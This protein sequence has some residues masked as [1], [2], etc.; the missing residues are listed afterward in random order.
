VNGV[1][2]Q[3]ELQ[4]LL[5]N[6]RTKAEEP[7]KEKLPTSL[8]APP[9]ETPEVSTEEFFLFHPDNPASSSSYINMKYATK[10]TGRTVILSVVNGV[11]R[12]DNLAT[13]NELIRQ[14]FV[15]MYSRPKGGNDG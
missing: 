8:E 7:S 9:L 11:I 2:T 10:V 1:L 13:R 5:K 12:T 15:L 3:K 14:G 4:S 6:K